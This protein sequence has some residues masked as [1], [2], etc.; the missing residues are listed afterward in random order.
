MI[1]NSVKMLSPYQ[2]EVVP[3]LNVGPSRPGRG[4]QNEEGGV[5]SGEGGAGHCQ[6]LPGGQSQQGE[7]TGPFRFYFLHIFLMLQCHIYSHRYVILSYS[8]T[9][10]I[11]HV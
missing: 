3:P 6:P 8:Y 4:G 5:T 11:K 10:I 2:H 7:T 1:D 9:N